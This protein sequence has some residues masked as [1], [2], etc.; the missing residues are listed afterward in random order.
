M[1][2][3]NSFFLTR[4]IVLGKRV[5]RLFVTDIDHKRMF[6]ALTFYCILLL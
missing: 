1:V 4:K 5:Q 2:D 3:C 6:V